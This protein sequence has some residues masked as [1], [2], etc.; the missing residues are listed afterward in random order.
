[1]RKAIIAGNWKMNK[2]VNEAVE[3]VKELKPLVKDAKCDVV[4]CPT[5]VCLS[6]VLKETEGSNVAVG[7][8]NMHFEESG[9]FTGEISPKMLEEMGVKYVILGHSER[10]QYF[11]ETDETV[12]KKVKKAFEHNLLPIVCC[13]E[14][15]EQ[16]EG[17]ITEDVLG[18]QIKIDLKDLE[19]EQVEKLVVAYEPIW[20]IGTGKTATNEQANETIGY[21]RSVI[22]GMYGKEVAEKVRIQYGG[23]VKPHTIKEQMEEKE[24]DG[25]LVGGASLKANDFSA[26][27]NY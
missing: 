8:Q 16:R 6:E 20:A 21:I 14:T 27:V 15:L 17:N 3:L 25:A 12:N 18:M 24:I 5:Y 13:G 11:N 9:A 22:E 23:S 19:K 26:I 10:R 4:V 2:T 7:A 1:M